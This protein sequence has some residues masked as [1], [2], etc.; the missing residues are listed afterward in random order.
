MSEV[1]TPAVPAAPSDETWAHEQLKAIDPGL[2]LARHGMPDVLPVPRSAGAPPL[3]FGIYPGGTVAN[4]GAPNDPERI[5]AALAELRGDRRALIVRGYL[6]YTDTDAD[7]TGVTDEPENVAQYVRDGRRLDLVLTYNA[8]SGNVDGWVEYVREAVRRYGAVAHT[9]QVTEEPNLEARPLDGGFPNVRD[10]LVRGVVAAKEEARRLG[11][12]V[13][14]GFNGILWSD[15]DDD[16]WT[17]VGQRGGRPF[18]EALDYVGLDLFP[19]VFSPAVPDGRHGDLRHVVV[20]AL[21]HYRERDLAAAGIPPTV[22]LH[23]TEQG[24]ATSPTRSEE[25]QSEVLETVIRTVNDY[26]G[27]FN[28]RACGAFCLRDSDSSRGDLYHEFGLMRDDYSPKR[29][30]E[31]F[32]QL[33]AELSA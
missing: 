21:R 16:F 7:W 22:P 31:T 19:Q 33:I 3:T 9:L 23:V 12:T 20:A 26:R 14:I 5:D 4:A 30:F 25:R 2:F 6:H 18:V 32:R 13:E 27:N 24:W 8:A 29:A 10:A 15:P 11:H 1:L 28:V 17:D